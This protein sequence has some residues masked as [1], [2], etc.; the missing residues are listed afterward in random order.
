MQPPPRQTPQPMQPLQGTPQPGAVHDAQRA[1]PSDPPS[2]PLLPTQGQ[3]LSLCDPP[4]APLLPTQGQV[5]SL[6][7]QPP[8]PAAPHGPRYP[9][10]Q[11]QPGSHTQQPPHP[12]PCEPG[13]PQQSWPAVQPQHPSTAAAPAAPAAPAAAPT[14]EPTCAAQRSVTPAA[15]V[16]TATRPSASAGRVE[17]VST[18]AAA[19]PRAAGLS[20][21]TP[22][23]LEIKLGLDEEVCGMCM[24][25]MHMYVHMPPSPIPHARM[26]PCPYA[27]MHPCP[28][29][30]MPPCPYAP[31]AWQ[32]PAEKPKRATLSVLFP[33]D[34]ARLAR[35]AADLLPASR[36]SSGSGPQWLRVGC[37]QY[38]E[39]HSLV[40]LPPALP[41]ALHV[42]PRA[43]IHV[44]P[45]TCFHPRASTCFH[46]LPCAQ[47]R[48]AP[49]PRGR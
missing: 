37:E 7:H 5:L 34:L 27:P 6:L 35:R 22:R 41:P 24:C 26:H 40:A 19:P 36:L 43:S 8:P 49:L 32:G 45:S 21:S 23:L 17:P 33:P 31:R 13:Q 1:R 3:V 46:V 12:Q 9:Q 47:V 15:N 30:R 39:L 14:A 42:F 38:A 25:T 18:P 11:W 10:P 4:S 2:A 28:H 20:P 44:L 16:A 29:A 48:G